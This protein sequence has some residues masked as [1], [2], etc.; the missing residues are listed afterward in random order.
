LKQQL[1]DAKV[2][3]EQLA[4]LRVTKVA[5]EEQVRKL[6]DELCEA[7]STHTPVIIMCYGYIAL[8]QPVTCTPGPGSPFLPF[9][10]ANFR[11]M[12]FNISPSGRP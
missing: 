12:L 11:P 1:A 7:K 5:L 6:T 10:S 3:T 4:A 9:F 2:D 8:L